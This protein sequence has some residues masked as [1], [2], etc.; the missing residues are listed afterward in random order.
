MRKGGLSGHVSEFGVDVTEDGVYPGVSGYGEGSM[1]TMRDY[2]K[3][4][5]MIVNRGSLFYHVSLILSR[6]V[7]LFHHSNEHRQSCARFVWIAG[8]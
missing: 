2:S 7:G 1:M 8:R 4:L 5:R 6:F 3:L